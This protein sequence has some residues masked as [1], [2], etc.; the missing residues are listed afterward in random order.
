MIS[1]YTREAGV[2]NLER[3]IAALARAAAVKV[4][5]KHQSERVARDMQP[6]AS[7]AIDQGQGSAG[8]GDSG[9]VELVVEAD[10]HG[11]EVAHASVDLEPLLVDEAVLELV[12]G[13]YFSLILYP[14]KS[15]STL[16]TLVAF[17]VI[18]FHLKLHDEQ[19]RCCNS[20]LSLKSGTPPSYMND[21]LGAYWFHLIW[22]LCFAAS[23]V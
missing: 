16:W 12:L 21:R 18:L 15:R 19:P 13:V 9:E 23:E 5:E 1:R 22:F 14:K 8:L 3:H 4:A 10:G 7:Q 2:R 6:E 20:F 11:R 17:S